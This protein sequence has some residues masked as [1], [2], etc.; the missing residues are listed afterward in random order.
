M[1]N[2]YRSLFYMFFTGFGVAL[3]YILFLTSA[4]SPLLET[5]IILMSIVTI[6]VLVICIE[7]IVSS[8]KEENKYENAETEQIGASEV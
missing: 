6:L 8:E 1:K 4:Y 5:I 7:I 2:I 3:Y